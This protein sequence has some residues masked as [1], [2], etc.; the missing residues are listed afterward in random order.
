MLKKKPK[1]R[2]DRNQSVHSNGEAIER[3]WS[4]GTQEDRFEKEIRKGF[5]RVQERAKQMNTEEYS[6]LKNL[7]EIA[8]PSVWTDQ[9]LTTL[10]KGVKRGKWYSL[11]DKVY[12]KANVE[13]STDAVLKGGEAPGVEKIT[14]ECYK[15]KREHFNEKLIEDLT[16]NEYR[17][18]AIRRTYIPKAGRK[19]LRP[20]GI[21][22]IRDR[23]VQKAILNVIEP[24]FENE[25][26]NSSYGFRP[27]RSCKDALR[28]ADKLL[29]E[30]YKYVLDADI[31]SFFDNI[32]HTK[33]LELLRE[34]ITD[35]KVLELIKGMLKQEIMEEIKKWTPE[36]GTPQGGV[37]SPLLA[38]IYLD[39]L[40]KLMES[41]GYK[42]IRYADDFIILCKD[43][44]EAE[45]AHSKI[46]KW[47]SEMKLTLHSEKT[48]IVDMTIA[49][50]SFNFLGYRFLNNKNRIK[51][52]PSDKSNKKFKDSIR[53]HTKRSN[54]NSLICIIKNITPIMRGWFEYYKHSRKYIFIALDGWVR[55]RLRSILRKRK[56]LR[57]IAKGS[58]NIDWPNKFFEDNGYFSLEGAYLSQCQ[59]LWRKC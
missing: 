18:E 58:S 11:M 8:E 49:G 32:S 53:A 55:R 39:G 28:E 20:L 33:I 51:R 47:M 22:T 1:S 2:T 14:V 19:E 54:G 9:M 21:P 31:K 24:I 59:S 15:T 40:D 17:P 26:S 50:E 29:E 35:G 12:S 10:I 38:N 41:T 42:M 23:I 25:F 34:K 6:R 16:S 44:K 36:S 3:Q 37:I 5:T 30:G 56:K 43:R 7:R 57:G 48:R 13:A 46:N 45:E 27:K 52:V 4:E